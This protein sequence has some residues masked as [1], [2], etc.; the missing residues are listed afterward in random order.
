TFLDDWHYATRYLPREPA[1]FPPFT[2]RGRYKMQIVGSG[3]DRE[4]EPI[5]ELYFAAI[6]L[7][8]RRV[9]VTTPYFVPDDAIKTALTTA[10][11]RG[12]DV[13]ILVPRRSDSLIV[14]AA[15]RSYY[16]DVMA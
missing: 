14:T 3:P 6:A 7:A 9:Y 2:G 8:Q 11:L 5:R 16:D 12:V 13:R 4:V 10:A 15:A 1:Y